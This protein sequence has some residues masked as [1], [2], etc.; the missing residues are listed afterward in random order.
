MPVLNVGP[1]S[2]YPTIAAAMPFANPA[3]T[4]LLEAGY[5]NEAATVTQNGITVA[6]DATSTGIVLTLGA[7]V[8]TFALDGTAPIDVLDALDGDGI[9]GNDG[10]NVI[11]VTGGADAVNGGGGDGD[12]LVV[13]YRLAGSAVTGDSTSNFTDAGG[14]GSVTISGGIEHFTVLTGTG[15]DTITTGAGNDIIRT[16]EGASTVTAGEGANQIYGGSGAD[17][18]TAGSGGNHIDAGDGTNTL[19]SGGGADTIISGIGSDTIVAG[20]GN[21]VVAIRGG[22]D[23]VD[24][25]A[26]QDRLVVDY[27]AS[28]TAVTGGATGGNLLTGY[29]G[30]IA[31]LASNVVD[32]V[33]TEHFSV[34][35]GS[36]ND[37]ISTGAGNDILIGNAGSDQ[38]R[39][40]A[41]L[42][43]VQGGAGG[44]LLEVLDGDLVT[45]ETYDGGADFD[46]LRTDAAALDLTGVTVTNIES[47]E[48]S[49]AAGT[50]FKVGSAA[51]A[52]LVHGSAGANDSLTLVGAKLTE[53]QR[54]QILSQ[55]IESITEIGEVTGTGG[56][57]TI[58]GIDGDD[59]LEGGPGNDTID[60]RSGD[61]TLAGGV[62]DDA[63]LGG[64][65]NDALHGGEGSDRLHGG[66][67]NDILNGG[68]GPDQMTGGSGDDIYTV[69][70]VGDVVTELA[71]E[72]TDLV[73][74]SVS[75]TLGGNVENLTL[76]GAGAINGSGNA[77]A[78]TIL[79]NSAGNRLSG[80]AGNDTLSGGSGDD[81]LKGGAGNDRLLGGAGDDRM[82]GGTGRDVMKGDAG[83]D[84]FDFNRVSES[85]VG[86]KRDIVVFSHSEG[87]E[88]DLRGIDAIKGGGNQRFSWAD[89][90]DLDAAFTGD[91][92]QL[93][94]AEGIL[95]GDIDGDGKADFE[96]KIM[97]ALSAGDV[98]L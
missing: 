98:I 19:T 47:V 25:G 84:V 22:A 12:R 64:A 30:H 61:D 24:S 90:D 74:S 40:G 73:Q 52:V 18:V 29:S 93:R 94:F 55:G 68:A 86:A 75:F 91:A 59:N 53:A 21:D 37:V 4:I 42:D 50:A 9:V 3:D 87:D 34:T 77:L 65:G 36:G 56:D 33:G 67:G 57:D 48:T 62:G 88:I 51:L 96:I 70:E 23:S 92:G 81:I 60:G 80:G 11:T 6:G 31:D 49:R 45:G 8:A 38:L 44:D 7:G 26:D 1:N 85:K 97:G 14:L 16:G 71:G 17:T 13:D 10:D 27:S 58:T 41:G 79:G 95:S 2:T 54:N 63:L 82:F 46:T 72:G 69:D 28:T 43:Q 66:M 83:A 5:G 78:N 15:T 32:F 35:S 20:G 76:M 39:G 89:A